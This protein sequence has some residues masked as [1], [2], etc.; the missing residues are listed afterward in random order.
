MQRTLSINRLFFRSLL[1]CILLA[2]WSGYTFSYLDNELQFT[3]LGEV[4]G[5]QEVRRQA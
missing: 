3:E 2:S 4:N 1:A 5:E